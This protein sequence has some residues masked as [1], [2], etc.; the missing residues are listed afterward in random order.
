MP[1]ITNKTQN[2]FQQ[3][4]NSIPKAHAATKMDEVL[5]ACNI[6]QATFYLWMRKGYAPNNIIKNS[7]IEILTQ[8]METPC[9]K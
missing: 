8:K 7:I 4:Y 1:K 3:A 9:L 5:T 6:S 2:W